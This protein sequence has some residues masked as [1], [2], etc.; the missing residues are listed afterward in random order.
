MIAARSRFKCAPCAMKRGAI[1]MRAWPDAARRSTASVSVGSMISRNA[2][3]TESCGFA[4]ATLRWSV[5]KGSAHCGSRDPCAKRISARFSSLVTGHQSLFTRASESARAAA[6]CVKLVDEFESD[7]HDR[8]DDE[9]GEALH[10]LD[11][12]SVF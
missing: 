1:V 11:R 10:R 8:Y 12:E 5:R 7:L 6:A 3:S 9:L 2:T 4:L